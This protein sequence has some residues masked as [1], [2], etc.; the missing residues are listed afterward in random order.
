PGRPRRTC[1][2]IPGS[3]SA[4]GGPVLSARSTA[5]ILSS[6]VFHIGRSRL[7]RPF[8]AGH[9]EAICGGKLKACRRGFCAVATAFVPA[10]D[11]VGQ[12]LGQ[13]LCSPPRRQ[14][15]RHR[16]LRLPP[17]PTL[18]ER[19]SVAQAAS[20]TSPPPVR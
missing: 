1:P 6:V 15:T 19:P 17:G 16:H 7:S 10:Q 18:T 14:F 3:A 20:R 8:T 11:A 9:T 4:P 12:D 5:S 13:L 2:S